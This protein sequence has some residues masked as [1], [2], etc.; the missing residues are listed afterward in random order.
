MKHRVL[1]IPVLLKRS[2]RYLLVQ[3]GFTILLLV[4]WLAAMRLFTYAV[5]GLVGTFSNAVLVLGSV[6]GAGLVWISAPV[7]RQTTQRIDRAFFRSAYDARRILESL[8]E[9]TRTVTSRD[10]LAVLLG[11]DIKQA[12][13]PVFAAVYLA[14]SDGQLRVYPDDS[15]GKFSPLPSR[16]SLLQELAQQ[17]EPWQILDGDSRGSQLPDGLSIFAPNHPECLV[18]IL[19]RGGTLT[20]LL[21]LGAR[22]AEE[23]YSRE[24]TRLLSAVAAQAE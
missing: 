18:P 10:E 2:A 13:H 8:V 14:D 16:A 5:S 9:E 21:V 1:E 11:S 12:L 19:M 23:P 24:D 3:R 22:L 6:F 17:K 15:P 7:V 20:G 4:I